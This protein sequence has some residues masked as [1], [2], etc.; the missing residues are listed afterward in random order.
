MDTAKLNE[1]LLELS[2][3]RSWDGEGGREQVRLGQ[4]Y[5]PFDGE[6][7]VMLLVARRWDVLAAVYIP[8]EGSDL[9][10]FEEASDREKRSQMICYRAALRESWPSQVFDSQGV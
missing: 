5:D 1:E 10:R 2:E 7:F 6:S 3:E 4:A 8:K 9:R